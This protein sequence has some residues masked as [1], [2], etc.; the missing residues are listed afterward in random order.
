MQTKRKRTKWDEHGQML[1]LGKVKIRAEKYV[2]TDV[3]GAFPGMVARG[4]K[5]AVSCLYFKECG[6]EEGGDRQGW[7]ARG[8]RRMF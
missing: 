6:C 5:A 7:K 1:S 3:R 8:L 2:T 4:T